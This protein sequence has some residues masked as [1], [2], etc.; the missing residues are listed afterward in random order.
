VERPRRSE[1]KRRPSC[2]GALDSTRGFCLRKQ[3]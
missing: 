1:W 2:D 3:N